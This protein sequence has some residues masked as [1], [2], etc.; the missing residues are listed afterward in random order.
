MAL[1]PH[2]LTSTAA[3]TALLAALALPALAQPAA[4][5][6][7]AASATSEARHGRMHEMRKDRMAKHA[8]ELKAKL[9]LT[10]AQEG[11]WTTFTEAMKPQQGNARLDF[12]DLRSL[13][14][15]ER[16]DRMR[17]MRAQRAAEADR[18][19]EATKAFYAQLSPA[20]QKTFDEQSMHM[21]GRMH[22][23]E[24]R[25]E[26]GHHGMGMQGR[27]PMGKGAPAPAQQ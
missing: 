5:P 25:H 17:A 2:R 1:F 21:M 10:P 26:G 7:P 12:Q 15:P 19:G 9:Q 24:H 13:S 11:A 14:T 8:A 4:A 20:Q 16:I 3:A 6:A 22:R 23:M 27:P 18:R